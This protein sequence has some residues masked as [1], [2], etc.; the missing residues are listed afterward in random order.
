MAQVRGDSSA[1]A[2]YDVDLEWIK[3]K[4]VRSVA[5]AVYPV[6][7]RTLGVMEYIGEKVVNLLG[8]NQ[9]RFQYA[10]D[11]QIRRDRIKQEKLDLER[12]RERQKILDIG[13]QGIEAAVDTDDDIPY[14]PPLMVTKVLV[15]GK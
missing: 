7:Q 4:P 1:E 10:V 6:C 11:E 5:K 13:L 8:L 9:S 14:A 2:Y 12:E 3:F 15:D